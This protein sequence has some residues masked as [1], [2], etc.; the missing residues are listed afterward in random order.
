MAKEMLIPTLDPIM[1][2]FTE[3]KFGE[4]WVKSGAS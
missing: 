1:V 2:P 4:I 3:L